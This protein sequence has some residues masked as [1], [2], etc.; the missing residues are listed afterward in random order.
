MFPFFQKKQI[1]YTDLELLQALR[2]SKRVEREKAEDA[3]YLMHYSEI[4][5]FLDKQGATA[6]EA[7][8]ICQNAVIVFC[9][10]ARNDK[11]VPTAPIKTYLTAICENKW[12]EKLEKRKNITI[13]Q[14]KVESEFDAKTNEMLQQFEDETDN[15]DID[16]MIEFAKKE[17]DKLGEKCK[18]ILSSFFYDNRTVEQIAQE[19]DYANG[20]IA[21]SQKNKCMGQLRKKTRARPRI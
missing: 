21:K 17:V 3:A 20:K 5:R 10:K 18:N 6:Y 4:Q 14:R 2:S 19:L 11:F 16:E 9:E 12:R 1:Y 15:P 7:E 8:E 13:P